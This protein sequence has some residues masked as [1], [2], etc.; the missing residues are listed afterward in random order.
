MIDTNNPC[1]GFI[2]WKAS[3][4]I[5]GGTP[6]KKNS[7]D[8]VNADEAP[9]K[10]LRAFAT[11]SN[12]ISLVFDEPLNSLGASEVV[13]YTISDGIG[14]PLSAIPVS[15]LFDK[16][17]LISSTPLLPD[18]AY[19]ITVSSLTDCAGNMIGSRNSANSD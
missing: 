11:D 7:I 14:V 1:G 10:L 9:P 6:G 15:P 18:K 4:N 17:T 19:I 3:A 16:V 2:N 5:S 12:T 8:A 13:N